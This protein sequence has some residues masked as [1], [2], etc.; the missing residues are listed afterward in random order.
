[1]AKYC[2]GRVGF[3]LI[4]LLVVIAIIAILAAILFPV[5]VSA[6]KKAQQ[7]SCNSNMRQIGI[8]ITM[9]TNEWNGALPDQ[10]SVIQASTNPRYPNPPIYQGANY[11]NEAGYNWIY[12]YAHRYRTDNGLAPD[13]MGKP[14]SKYIKSL[15]VFRCPSQF[16]PDDHNVP[17]P[18]ASSYYYKL[19]LMACASFYRHP[20]TVS[21]A[22]F[23]SRA[24]MLYEY[25]WHSGYN[26]PRTYA[27]TTDDGA[28]KR[29]SVVFL[30]S[31]VGYVEMTK[32]DTHYDMNWYW[33]SMHD[34]GKHEL[35]WDIT[36]GA[37]D[38]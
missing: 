28:T 8:A 22:R 33:R 16:L 18:G 14:L 1:M 37:Y 38:R 13:G 15:K 4:E 7:T 26:D 35:Q 30:D 32:D 29:F 12:Y 11:T 31:H 27:T 17:T 23:P 21:S 24:T 10:G 6:R 34:T 2:R 20:M 9:Y 25:P 19:A 3:T 36:K 5:F